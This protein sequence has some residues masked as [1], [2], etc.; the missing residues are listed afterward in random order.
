[1]NVDKLFEDKEYLNN[2]ITFFIE[3]KQIRKIKSNLELVNS[4]LEKAKHNLAF[5]K[6]NKDQDEFYDWLIVTLYYSLYHCSLAL[7]TNKNYI[8]KNHFA[9]ILLLI[10][11]YSISKEDIQLIN[12]LSINKDD[13]NL[14]TT[15]KEDRHN[16]SY[17]TNNKFTKEL[18]DEYEKG[19]INFIIKTEEILEN[20]QDD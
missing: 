1:M 11:E 13:A 8:S 3:Q 6:L 15:L 4:H 12:N 2:Q 18:I 19:V 20:G 9:T 10:K 17:S 7:I 16:A 14:Y 5:Y